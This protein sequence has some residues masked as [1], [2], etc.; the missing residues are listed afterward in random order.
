MRPRG[1]EDLT[2]SEFWGNTLRIAKVVEVYPEAHAVDLVFTDDASR[3]SG[4]MVM[5]P[6]ASTNTGFVDLPE[7][8]TLKSGEKWSLE[9]TEDRDIFA[10]VA[11]TDGGL[12]VLGFLFPQVAQA[13]FE[14]LGRMIY[15]HGSDVYHTIDKRGNLELRHPSGL[16]VRIGTDPAHEDLTEKDYDEKWKITK[17][18]YKTPYLRIEVANLLNVVGGVAQNAAVV[19]AADEAADAGLPVEGE[20]VSTPKVTLTIAPDGKLTLDTVGNITVHSATL[21]AVTA[22]LI[23]LN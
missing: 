6:S 19:A 8:A 23:T 14:E 21:V 3:A 9:P 5:V 22:P 17:N 2:M 15:R 10:V 4:V 7:P 11:P 12:I 16:F 1:A 20:F 18:L 13:M